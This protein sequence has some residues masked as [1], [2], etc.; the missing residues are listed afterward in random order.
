VVLDDEVSGIAISVAL[1]CLALAA[2]LSRSGC[3]AL[4]VA[5]AVGSSL[6][7]NDRW[8]GVAMAAVTILCLAGAAIS[9]NSD[10]LVQ[11]IQATL[12]AAP[13]GRLTIW[14]D[15][16]PIIRDF[17]VLGTGAGTFADAMLTYQRTDKQVL[18]NHA[19]NEYLQLATE[20][21]FV[22]LLGVVAAMMALCAL[23]RRR[24]REDNGPHRLI[25]VGA[26]AGLAGIAVQSIWDTGLHEPA[27]LLLAA[28][29][30]AIAVRPNRADNQERERLAA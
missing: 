29:V 16:L 3:V 9:T 18:F 15:T 6:A 5:A 28:L 12:D 24:L 4:V 22:L 17:P 21:G 25:R 14:R 8:R 23:V 10:G 7:G 13:I 19:H 2:T 11:R 20:G 26:A 1:M 27:N 30:A